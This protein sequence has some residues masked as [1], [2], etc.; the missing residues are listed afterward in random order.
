MGMPFSSY[1]FNAWSVVNFRRP[2]MSCH[3]YDRLILS[4]LSRSAVR[5]RLQTFRSQGS[6]RGFRAPSPWRLL[7]QFH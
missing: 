3:A 1:S 2:F 5:Q 6:P 4:T 7:H